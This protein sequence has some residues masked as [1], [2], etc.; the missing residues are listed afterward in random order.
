LESKENACQENMKY[1]SEVSEKYRQCKEELASL[2][3]IKT[4]VC[5]YSN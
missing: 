4:K 2:Q 5:R 1:I 3:E